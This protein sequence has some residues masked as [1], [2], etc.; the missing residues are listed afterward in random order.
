M[1]KTLSSYFDAD[2][3]MP[4]GHCFLWLPQILWL[5]VISD[6]LIAAAYY[7]IPASLLYF[8]GRRM[9]IP[10][11][12]LFYLFGAFILLCG[13][14][15][16]LAIW[17]IWHPD[18]AIEGLVKALTAIV[19]V[20][21]AIVSWKIIPKALELKGPAELERVNL[22]LL[23]SY[24]NIEQIVEARTVELTAVNEQLLKS[25]NELQGALTLAQ[26]ANNAKSEFLA[27]MSHEIRTPMNAVMGLA[28]I[29]ANSSPLTQRQKEYVQTLQLSTNSLLSLINDFLDI[30]R[31]E[32]H[33][34]DL[35]LI[36][37]RVPELLDEV[38]SMMTL[39]ASDK[40]LTLDTSITCDCVEERMF[41]G[42]PA[43]LRQILLNLCSNAV[44]FTKQ[45]TVL[46]TASCEK[47]DQ[48]D[49]EQLILSVTDTGIGIAP[50]KLEKIF[51]KFVQADS[52]INRKYGGTGL[53]LAIAK[54]LVQL[55]GGSITAQSEV[56]KGSVFTVCIPLKRSTELPQQIVEKERVEETEK[57]TGPRVLLVEDYPANVLVAT[58]FL[59][60][61]GYTYDV[62][63]TGSEAVDRIH[64]ENYAA[65]LMDVQMPD[66]NG[67]DATRHIREWEYQSK[68][69]RIPII[70][71]TANALFGDRERCLDS[72]MDD[73]IAKPFN[74]DEL[75]EKL[76]K[77]VNS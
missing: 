8:V 1:L 66:M 60:Q 47:T 61:F 55:M 52:S 44:K 58:T 28:H 56:G 43:R 22:Q 63:L 36:P 2:N 39:P 46:L 37:F 7:S 59:E 57:L 25:E 35:E 76:K 74:P 5:H 62:S 24:A 69:R 30:S 21:T 45:G 6:A 75:K 42:D 11:K 51:L 68:R 9:D 41:I 10:F 38:I 15:H 20:G 40:G 70:G 34:V 73:Y 26:E 67:Y 54:T 48:K 64:K 16:I 33:R 49:V 3:F 17:V 14:T 65:V 18:Y 71:M 27:N 50:D 72:G 19:S 53:G 23:R 12:N 4:H 77:A 13:T 32:S 29:L 31:I